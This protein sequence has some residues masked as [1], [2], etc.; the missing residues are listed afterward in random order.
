MTDRGRNADRATSY[1]LFDVGAFQ[2]H[3]LTEADL[4]A[5]QDFFVANPDYFLAVNGMAP[6]PDEARHE[7]DDRPPPEM[8]FNEVYVVGFVD[9]AGRLL[10]MASVI[11]DLVADHV[12]HIGLFIVATSLHGTGTATALYAGLEGW[13]KERGARWIRL[14]AVAGNTRAERFWERLG[15]V[16]VRRRSGPHLGNRTHTVRVFVKAVRNS[17]IDEYLRVVA[18]DRP[19]SQLP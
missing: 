16:E 19:D 11:S 5:L 9:K 18:R 6:R 13:L 12:W 10:A 17:D 4:P 3:E 14:G 15:Y 8:P 1:H 2:A 7:F